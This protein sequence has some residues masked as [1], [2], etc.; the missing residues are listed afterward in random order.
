MELEKTFSEEYEEFRKEY[1]LPEFEKLAE[2]FDIEKVAEKESSFI[3]REI[4][5]MIHEKLSAYL[6]LFEMLVNPNGPPMFMFGVLKRVNGDSKE[7]VK[8]LYE[9]LSR[10][11]ITI[12]KLD[13]VYSEKNEA[14]FII[15][16]F[17]EWQ[18]IKPQI[19][20][21][22]EQFEKSMDQNDNLKKTS[23]FG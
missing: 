2:D 3:L 17:E 5:R 1:S 20:S 8:E 22:V 23:Y 10:L 9:N 4:R 15:F 16:A 7:V 6:S 18:K 21:L 14:D 19:Y 12:M 11:Q 13:T